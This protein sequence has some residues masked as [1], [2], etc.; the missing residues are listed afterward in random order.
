MHILGLWVDYQRPQ[1]LKSLRRYHPFWSAVVQGSGA[2][3]SLAQV[4]SYVED[5]GVFRRFSFI[6]I[7]LVILNWY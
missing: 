6:Q 7:S 3:C 2:S 1:I 4:L 5:G